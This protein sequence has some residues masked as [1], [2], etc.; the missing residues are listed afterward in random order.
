MHAWNA[1][2]WFQLGTCFSVPLVLVNPVEYRY[3]TD[4]IETP[5][6]AVNYRVELNTP[7]ELIATNHLHRLQSDMNPYVPATM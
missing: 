5:L 3:N 7:G 1:T 6:A 4:S 2:A